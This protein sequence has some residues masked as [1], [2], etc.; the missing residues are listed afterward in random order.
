MKE[1]SAETWAYCESGV[2]PSVISASF[3]TAWTVALQA[4][5]FMGFLKQEY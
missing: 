4:P 2:G 1:L 5:L 3:A